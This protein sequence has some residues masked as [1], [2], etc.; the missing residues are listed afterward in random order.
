[1]KSHANKNTKRTQKAR[2]EAK[3]AE[4]KESKSKEKKEIKQKRV[5]FTAASDSHTIEGSAHKRATEIELASA[6]MRWAAKNEGSC[7][8]SHDP[9]SA[10]S[11]PQLPPPTHKAPRQRQRRRRRRRRSFV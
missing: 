10:S 3:R 9:S 7:N 6:R 4:R 1:M 5:K 2:N 8:R 11:R